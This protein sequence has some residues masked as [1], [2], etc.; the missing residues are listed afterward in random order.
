MPPLRQRD[1]SVDVAALIIKLVGLGVV[2]VVTM[3]VR[4]K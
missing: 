1:A 4:P 3:V 2:V